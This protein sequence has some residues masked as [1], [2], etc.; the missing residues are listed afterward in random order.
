MV[1]VTGIEPATYRSRTDRATA[2]LHPEKQKQ[3]GLGDW[4]RTS[5]LPVPGRK[6]YQAELHLENLCVGAGI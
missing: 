4:I 2:A 3:I 1:G 5:G 6:L